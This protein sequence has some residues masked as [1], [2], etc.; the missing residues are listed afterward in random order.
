MSVTGPR[1]KIAALLLCFF[2][3]VAAASW[4]A[5]EPKR[6]ESSNSG[7]EIKVECAVLE[8]NK[9]EITVRFFPDAAP[10]AV[11]N[12]QQLSRSG[13][14]DGVIFH[15]VIE[16]FMI[17][18]GDP[19]GTGYGGR[20]VWEVPFEDEFSTVLR[21]DRK[22]LLAM[23]NS[24]PRSNGSQFFITLAPTQWLDDKHTIFGEVVEGMDVVDVIGEVETYDV[25]EKRDRPVEDVVIEKIRFEDR[26]LE[27]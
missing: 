13:Y 26:I 5:Q 6:A 19:T 24:G 10:K 18:G 4:A 17:Q 16:G 14:Y 3:L 11:E 12:F 20:S 7:G 21:F 9:G 2:Y 25:G 15:R 23:A 8:T 1:G 27:R 22:G